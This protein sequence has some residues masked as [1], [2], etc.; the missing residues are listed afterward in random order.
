MI[1][2]YGYDFTRGRQDLTHHPFMTKFSGGDVRITTHVKENDLR[3]ALFST[4]HEAGHALYEQG[5]NRAYEAT[6]LNGGTSSGVHESQSRL[7]ENIVGRSREFWSFYYPQ[8]Q[9]VF[10]DQLGSVPLDAFHR[11][12]NK[13]GALAD[14]HRRRRSDL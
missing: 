12:V 6:P 5:I 7:W 10:P 13:V 4:L 14:P 9:A 2:A 11:A 1:K 8:L 3:D